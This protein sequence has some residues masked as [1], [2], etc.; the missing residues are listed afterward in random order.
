MR[1]IDHI[2]QWFTGQA[3]LSRNTF[4]DDVRLLVQ[5]Y[6]SGR[7]AARALG[8]A[9][10]TFRA[11]R[12]GAVPRGGQRRDDIKTAA[13]MAA[14]DP[15]KMAAAEA[16]DADAL[17]TVKGIFT[18]SRDSRIR[19]IHPGRYIPLPIIRNVLDLWRQGQDAA[20]E[21]ALVNAADHY[22]QPFAYDQV[23]WARFGPDRGDNLFG[24]PS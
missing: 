2:G 5:H 3:G 1:L 17:L 14:T 7:A 9:E 4:T 6:G 12:H 8:V 19:T 21:R 11:W 22:Y 20:A 23:F 18:V 10:S 13:R 24:A 15:D 16:G